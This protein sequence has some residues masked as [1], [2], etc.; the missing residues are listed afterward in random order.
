MAFNPKVTTHF[1]VDCLSDCERTPKYRWYLCYSEQQ[2]TEEQQGTDTSFILVD[3]KVREG[4]N[5]FVMIKLQGNDNNNNSVKSF[6]E[7]L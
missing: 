1:H 6:T 3:N 4:E 2:C 5:F 7:I